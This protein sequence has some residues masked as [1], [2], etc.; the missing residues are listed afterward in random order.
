MTA[1]SQSVQI[2]LLLNIVSVLLRES[3]EESA[4][5]N[6]ACCSV[7]RLTH[8]Y[9]AN[10]WEMIKTTHSERAWR[11]VVVHYSSG[12]LDTCVQL[13]KDWRAATGSSRH[14]Y[15]IIHSPLALW[16]MK[17]VMSY[18]VPCVHRR[19][20]INLNNC[21]IWTSAI[22]LMSPSGVWVRNVLT[23]VGGSDV[24]FCRQ[25]ILCICSHADWC[26]N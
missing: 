9:C 23:R 3:P 26:Q 21:C 13:S 17:P 5:N 2:R 22:R 8:I 15:I 4:T 25:H 10:M 19:I 18:L 1:H 16:Y 7:V 6:S 14:L 20:R 24:F 12:L 11:L